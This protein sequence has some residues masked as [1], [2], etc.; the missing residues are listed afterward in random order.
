MSME[1]NMAT[2]Q[3][4]AKT[5]VPNIE[6]RTPVTAIVVIICWLTI[7]AEGYDLGIYGAVLPAMLEAKEWGL[8]AALAGIIGSYALLGMLI[9]S[10]LVGVLTDFIGRKQTLILNLALFSITMGLAATAPSAEMFGFY[11]FIGGLGIGGVIPSVSALT[12]EYS[13]VKHR[14][15]LYVLMYTGYPIGGVLGALLSMT[16]IAEYGWK[17]LFWIG[18]LPILFIPFIIK[19]LPESINYL[20]AHNRE[21]EA[22]QI[23]QRYRITLVETDAVT[24][25]DPASKSRWNV[26]T[27]LFSQKNVRAT[28]FFWITYF[29]GFLM[30]YGLNTWLPKIMKQAGY[31]LG[32]SISFLLVF[33]L[34]AAIGALVAGAAADRF[35]SRRVISISYLLAALSTGLLSI[36][37][38]V[39]LVYALVGIAGF[40]TIGSTMVLASFVSNYY[41]SHNRATALGWAVGFGR[42]GAIMGPMLGGF[43]LTM[44]I[45]FVWNFLTFS[46]AGL[47]ASLAILFIPSKQG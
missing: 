15:F 47:V 12:I 3:I 22:R 17:L 11:R 24:V 35:G 26:I 6:S 21:D 18:V 9:G 25:T 32:S 41:P 16:L 5:L 20:L 14:S 38:G 43:L 45:D 44:Q 4:E 31:P 1:A 23:A 27:D 40:G 36:K 37:S 7:L 42:V 8:T 10:L 19:L 29:M 28:A 46:I 2:N 39:L 13:P 34:T 30:V 33:N